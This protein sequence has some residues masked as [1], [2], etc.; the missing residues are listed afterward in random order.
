VEKHNTHASFWPK[1]MA[2]PRLDGV[3]V[4][5]PENAK[6]AVVRGFSFRS[7]YIIEVGAGILTI[8]YFD[9]V[10]FDNVTV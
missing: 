1:E 3:V 10:T 8:P 2:G 4:S 6:R 9:R 7:A 5:T